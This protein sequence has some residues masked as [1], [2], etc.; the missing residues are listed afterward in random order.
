MKA[1]VKTITLISCVAISPLALAKHYYDYGKVIQVTPVYETLLVS[2]PQRTCYPVTEKRHH[3]N[4]AP[5]IVGAVVGSVIGHAIGHNRHTRKLASVAGASVGASIGHD[6]SHNH[7][8][9]SY[10]TVNHCEVS[11]QQKE[12]VGELSGYEV[13]Y[14]YKGDTYNT[15]MRNRPGDKIKLKVTVQPTAS[16]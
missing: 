1:L 7:A 6:I 2:T 13:A 8:R 16:D 5:T 9:A 14:R 3:Y 15:F 12:K 10:R 11:Y 4:P